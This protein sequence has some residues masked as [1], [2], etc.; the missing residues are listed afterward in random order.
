MLSKLCFSNLQI[1]HETRELKPAQRVPDPNT[2]AENKFQR[3][4]KQKIKRSL[5]SLGINLHNNRPKLSSDRMPPLKI[6]FYLRLK[7]GVFYA[8]IDSFPRDMFPYSSIDICH[9]TS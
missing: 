5:H 3:L 1:W 6:N 9:I 2:W 8:N 7:I 4:Q